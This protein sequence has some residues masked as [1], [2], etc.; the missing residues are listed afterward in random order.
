MAAPGHKQ[1]FNYSFVYTPPPRPSG[2][3]LWWKICWK[4]P[5]KLQILNSKLA[6]K[7][8]LPTAAGASMVAVS[9]VLVKR[10][11]EL[12]CKA[13]GPGEQVGGHSLK[14]I[15]VLSPFNECC[16]S[17]YLCF[18]FWVNWEHSD[19]MSTI[20]F[21]CH[22]AHD[23]YPPKGWCL[24]ACRRWLTVC[25]KKKASSFPQLDQANSIC[26]QSYFTSKAKILRVHLSVVDIGQTSTSCSQR[27][28]QSSAKPWL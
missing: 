24:L 17:L 8:E 16:C 12:T 26:F 18:T 25:H 21:C 7:A 4:Q 3:A 14:E 22:Q 19:K 5:P 15:F 11:W 27:K 9:R 23:G 10:I 1:L 6:G 2:I 28:S 20:L 13:Q